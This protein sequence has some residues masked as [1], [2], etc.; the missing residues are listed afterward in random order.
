MQ[1]IDQ[2]ILGGVWLYCFFPPDEPV[3][4]YFASFHGG[5]RG[6]GVRFVA[7]C[8]AKHICS[9]DTHLHWFMVRDACVG[10]GC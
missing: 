1:S 4:R 2:S 9:A 5:G 3:L 10:G 8:K 7:R 6:R